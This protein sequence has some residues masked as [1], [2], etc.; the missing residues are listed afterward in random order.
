MN[1][2]SSSSCSALFFIFETSFGVWNFEF[3][4]QSRATMEADEPSTSSGTDPAEEAIISVQSLSQFGSVSNFNSADGEFILFWLLKWTANNRAVDIY[5]YK[6]LKMKSS[7]FHLNILD[8]S[9]TG[10]ITHGE[11][12]RVLN[13]YGRYVGNFQACFIYLLLF[14]KTFFINI[15]KNHFQFDQAR[16]VLERFRSQNLS[17]INNAQDSSLASLFLALIQ[18]NLIFFFFFLIFDLFSD[19]LL[20]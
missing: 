7:F 9:S 13:E 2:P 12:E 4:V 16:L 18:A 15:F 6:I 20:W 10:P 19:L 11:V 5:F 1:F 14:L 17:V 8:I 3:L